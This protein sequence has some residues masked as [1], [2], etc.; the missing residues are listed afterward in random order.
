MNLLKNKKY[1]GLLEYG[2]YRREDYYPRIIDDLTFD[3]VSKRIESNKR[4]PARMKA[5]EN[6]RLSGKLHCGY[7]KSLM[8]GESGT[9]KNGTIHHYYK[10]FGKKR[11]NHCEKTSVKKDELENLVVSLVLKHILAEDKIL[12]TIEGIVSTYNE[13]VSQSTELSI[14]KQEYSQNEKYLNNI[15]TAIKNGIFSDTTQKELARLEQRK[16]DLE[17]SI[18]VQEALQQNKLTKEKV[19]FFFKKFVDTELGD[20]DAKTSIISHLV[21]KVILY[22]DK[23]RIILKNKDHHTVEAS[24]EELEN[25]CSNL[26]QL[27][28]PTK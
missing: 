3:I 1:T 9:S 17:E 23:I 13:T 15:L 26:T 21:Y 18:L 5:Y 14:L 4:S 11:H 24:I 6:Y 7:C 19:L 27:S 2:E 25:L 8:T 12:D 10:C 20:E 22:N 28:P 16:L